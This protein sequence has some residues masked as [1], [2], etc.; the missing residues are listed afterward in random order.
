ML[1]VSRSQLELDNI[2]KAL[3]GEKDLRLDMEK[4][5]V[6]LLDVFEINNT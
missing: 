4:R 5:Q 2:Q 1:S 3:E 6:G